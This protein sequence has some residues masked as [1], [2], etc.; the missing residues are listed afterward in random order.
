L[1]ADV[2][3]LEE[4]IMNFRDL[5]LVKYDY[6]IYNSLSLSSI[7]FNIFRKDYYD[8]EKLPIY[9]NDR[10]IDE[11]I[12]NSYIGGI[13]DVY[14]PIMVNGYCYDINSLY[15]YSMTKELPIGKPKY[16]DDFTDIDENELFGFFK[17]HVIAPY[18]YIPILPG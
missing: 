13:T 14:K 9:K 8:I 3:T 4:G 5:I 11:F 18:Q 12:R 15:P 10:K 2:L 16:I 1:K 7:A 17:V 6:D